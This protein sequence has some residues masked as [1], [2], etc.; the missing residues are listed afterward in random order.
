[1]MTPMLLLAQADEGRSGLFLIFPE[2]HELIWG[3][4]SFAVLVFILWKVAGP[5]MNRMLE[6]RQQAVVG[7]LQEAEQA[8]Q[9]AQGLLDDYRQQLANAKD[10]AN[11]IIEE[12]RQT[13][14]E[15]RS[16]LMAKAASEAEEIV[17]K[18]RA[19][20]VAERERALAEVRQEVADLSIDLA[21]RVVQGSLD[22]EA[23][24]GLI[25][26]YLDEL[27]RMG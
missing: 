18:A 24:R 10:E 3:V 7:G 20:V 11:R 19:E 6:T 5:A 14:E 16:E 27:E 4:V 15:L 23:Q 26:R 8:K 25:D 9:E 2:I 21:E 22:R 1:M 13:A 12:S 17:A